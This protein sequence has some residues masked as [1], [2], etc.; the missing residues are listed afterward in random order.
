MRT[1][2]V[3]PL[4]AL[5]LFVGISA[6]HHAVAKSHHARAK[7]HHVVRIA[8]ADEYFGR[9]KMSILGIQNQLRDLAL[10]LQYSP[11]L[12]ETVLGSAAMVE[13][14]MHDWEHKYPADPWLPKNVFQLTTLYAN[15]HTA[16][17]DRNA[18]RSLRWLLTRYPHTRYAAMAR[19][20]LKRQVGLR[21]LGSKRTY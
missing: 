1:P 15:V 18:T 4:A 8:P 7:A 17:G 9:L 19:A 16:H 2:A 3:L 5:F 21:S 12:G 6:P 11:Q 10:R 14:A 13:D 20:Q